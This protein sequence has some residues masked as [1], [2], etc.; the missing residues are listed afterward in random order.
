MGTSWIGSTDILSTR[1]AMTRSSFPEIVMICCSD[2]CI[3]SIILKLDK[4]YRA[5][6][7]TAAFPNT[8]YRKEV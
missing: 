1:K 7:V 2:V 3:K 4:H 8:I 5:V 6:A